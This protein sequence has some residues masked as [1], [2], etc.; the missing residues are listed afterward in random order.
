MS[1]ARGDRER[2]SDLSSTSNAHLAASP[3]RSPAERSISPSSLGGASAPMQKRGRGWKLPLISFKLQFFKPCLPFAPCRCF[4]WFSGR[5]KGSRDK[6]PRVIKPKRTVHLL[7]M[8]HDPRKVV[9]FLGQH[10]PTESRF[11]NS[12]LFDSVHRGRQFQS[13]H[14]PANYNT[15]L[16]FRHL[17]PLTMAS[18]GPATMSTKLDLAFICS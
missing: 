9:N 16:D 13:M 2:F 18:L 1:N 5:P 3:T 8:P 11:H 12:P 14:P 4:M 17:A 15:S 10:S 6:L 7:P